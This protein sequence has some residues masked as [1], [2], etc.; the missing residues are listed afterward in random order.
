MYKDHFRLRAMPFS[1]A[2]D[3]SYFYLSNQHREALTLL[4][5]AL[6][7]GGEVALLTGEVGAGKTTV[8]RRL[9]DDLPGHVD[10]ALIHNPRL[11]AHELLSTVCQS[12]RIPEADEGQP[13]DALVQRIATHVASTSAA[14]RTSLLIIDEAQSLSSD[15]LEQMRLLLEA[16]G[17]GLRIVLIGQPELNELLAQPQ[18]ARFAEIVNLRHHLGP[19]DRSD[20]NGYVQ[21]RLG[22]A[23]SK[24]QLVPR[25]LIARLH[26][27]SQGIPRVI[28]LICDR[29]L[30]GAFVLGKKA[31]TGRILAEARREALGLE[32]GW[33]PW[34]RFIPLALGAMGAGIAGVCF[35]VAMRSPGDATAASL[36]PLDAA[37]AALGQLDPM[38]PSD[39][40][41]GMGGNRSEALAYEALLKRWNVA[42]AEP[43]AGP[44]CHAPIKTGLSCVQGRDDLEYLRQLNA[45]AV[46]Q[47]MDR[48]GR[49]THVAVVQLQRNEAVLQLGDTVR[50]VPVSALESQWTRQYT[51]LWRPPATLAA[52]VAVGSGGPPV[53][54][55]RDRVARWKNVD[56]ATLPRRLDGTLKRHL[57]A[58]QTFEGLRAT[59][60]GDLRTLVHLAT[61]TEAGAPVLQAPHC[62]R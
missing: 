2:P 57:Q 46:V 30:L 52:P 7:H 36:L 11:T 48:R 32:S 29:A 50:R 24:Q 18:N 61:R 10:V 16:S 12:L 27:M 6:E 60:T 19:L 15:V 39:W 21:H 28:N 13:A 53:D 22:V 31:V 37:D 5:H 14:G 8:C 54:W 34:K 17:R 40:P 41:Q 3:P 44:P 35:A 1:I 20:V 56:A 51:L 38:D 26:R 47:L 59:G 58:F 33:W 4:R 45:P 55:I 49:K 43:L 9:L 25:R 42:P 62:E 23:G